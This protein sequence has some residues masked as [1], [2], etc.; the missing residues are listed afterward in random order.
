LLFLLEKL[1]LY[2]QPTMTLLFDYPSNGKKR[3][4][5]FVSVFNIYSEIG[6]WRQ[7]SP[8]ALSPSVPALLPSSH[9]PLPGAGAGEADSKSSKRTASAGTGAD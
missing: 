6:L 8:L 5:S 1:F 3:L 7:Q 2:L 9:P 4:K